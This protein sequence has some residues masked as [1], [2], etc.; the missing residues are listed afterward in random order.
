MLDNYAKEMWGSRSVRWLTTDSV[1]LAGGIILLW[2]ACSIRVLDS[3]A[4]QFSL[5]A[6][7][8]DLV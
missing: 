5:A 1:G 6:V 7:I 2:D 4:G 3:W 8:K